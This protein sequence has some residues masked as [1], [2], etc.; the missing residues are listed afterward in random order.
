MILNE[1]CLTKIE[2]GL[3]RVRFRRKDHGILY[4]TQSG[5]CFVLSFGGECFWGRTREAALKPHFDYQAWR[6][7]H[8]AH[9]SNSSLET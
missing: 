6:D 7:Y 9:A 1:I 2:A 5:W 8:V 4:R 3:Y